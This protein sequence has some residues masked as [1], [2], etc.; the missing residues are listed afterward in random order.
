MK[1]P[2]P[3]GPQC[4]QPRS[5]CRGQCAQHGFDRAH[6]RNVA[7]HHQAVTVLQAP[8]TSRHAGIDEQQ[9]ALSKRCRMTL[10]VLVHRVGTVDDDIARRQ[11]RHEPLQRLVR[12]RSSGQHQ[13]DDL[14]RWQVRH[15]FLQRDDRNQARLAGQCRSSLGRAVPG[16]HHVACTRDATAHVAA[17]P[18]QSNHSQREVHRVP[19]HCSP[20][21]AIDGRAMPGR[22]QGRAGQSSSR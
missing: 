1:C 13:P 21:G 22:A 18:A 14:R 10:A 5:C 19:I 15:E 17:H 3:A 7:A 12:G 9:S 16:N 20:A 4:T 8:H 11:Q 2:A 6:G